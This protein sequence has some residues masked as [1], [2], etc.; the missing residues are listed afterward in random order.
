M[1]LNTNPFC[2]KFTYFASISLIAF[3]DLFFQFFSGKISAPLIMNNF[4]VR[5]PDLEPQNNYGYILACLIDIRKNHTFPRCFS[6]TS[7]K[8]LASKVHWKF[9]VYTS[10]N[11]NL[12]F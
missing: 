11:D 1:C 6:Y 3:A 12:K 10:E 7:E 5:A 4:N 9:P 8:P 2:Q